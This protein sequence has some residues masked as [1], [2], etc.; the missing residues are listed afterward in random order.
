MMR[1]APILLIL[2]VLLGGAGKAWSADLR[3][4]LN[5]AKRGDYET[6][7]R[8]WRPLAE[9]GNAVAQTNIGRLYRNGWGVSKNYQTLQFEVFADSQ[10]HWSQCNDA[11]PAPTPYKESRARDQIYGFCDIGATPIG[12]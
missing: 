6:A 7:L 3:K 8:E 2:A 4:G 5:A 12:T 1:L 9:Q 11:H 10:T